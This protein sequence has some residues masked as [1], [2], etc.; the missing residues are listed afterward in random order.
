MASAAAMPVRSRYGVRKERTSEPQSEPSKKTDSVGKVEKPDCGQFI[1]KSPT[2]YIKM[3][4][5]I[6]DFGSR[7]PIR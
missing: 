4:S 5:G 7:N 1:R 2:F 6:F 3:F